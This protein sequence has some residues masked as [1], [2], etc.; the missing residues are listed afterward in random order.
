M[1]DSVSHRP[2]IL[3]VAGEHSGDLHAGRLIAQVLHRK[4][5][6]HFWGIGGDECRRAG[7]ETLVDVREMAVLGLW[8]V[9]KRYPHF[10]RVFN[11]V[12]QE[13]AARRPDLAILVDYPGFNLKLA[14]ALHEIGIPVV[15]YIC[16]QVWAWRRSRIN[17]MARVLRRLIVIF[18]FEKEAFAHTGLR[19]DYVGHPLVDEIERGADGQQDP[20]AWPGQPRIAIL[21]GSRRQ[22]I[23]RI[24]PPLWRAAGLIQTRLPKA[25]F[26]MVLPTQELAEFAHARAIE[27]GNG[28]L[29]Y[30][31]L[32]G[33]ARQVLAEATA[34]WVKSGTSTIEA[35]L[36]NCPMCIVYRTSLPTYWAGR[37]LV[38][39]PYLG[40]VNLVAGRKAFEEF[41]QHDATP[42]KLADGIW[43]LLHDTPE[44]QAAM[45]A[46]AD[47]RRALG[48]G[49][50]IG[51]AAE[52]VI[53]EL[54]ALSR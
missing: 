16:P 41:I 15:Y 46:L 7:M 5:G 31:V 3:L 11:L 44:R 45:A 17:L 38:R 14:K 6:V 36:M 50:A 22:E 39:V 40:M 29:H 13:A 33:C 21:P 47:V 32:H 43:P 52:I 19:V 27:T 8:E 24:L 35:A 28:P 1:N 34:A 37:L 26:V 49:G 4:P 18:P 48:A 2:S 25:G 9:I 54:E 42:G 20:I 53:E 51:R 10:K 12:R 30:T 23:E